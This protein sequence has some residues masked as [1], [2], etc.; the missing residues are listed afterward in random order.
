MNIA[1]ALNKKYVEYTAVMLLSLCMNNKKHH[2]DI[3]LLHSELEEN[4]IEKLRNT[5]KEYDVTLIETKVEKA[6]FEEKCKSSEQWSIETY[7]R[8]LLLDILPE[9]VERL[10][11]L[12][13]DMLIINDIFDMYN[14]E[15]NGN[16]IFVVKDMSGTLKNEFL[17]QKQ[18]E[19]FAPMFAQGYSYFNAGLLLYNIKEMR[20]KYSTNTYFDA[21]Q[22]WNYEMTAFDQDIMNYVH[23]KKVSYLDE[24]KYNVF[25]AVAH[26]TWLKDYA[27]VKENV[28]IIHY[29]GFMKPWH[30]KSFHNDIELI[31]WEYAK[32]TPFYNELLERFMILTMTD[33]TF[34]YMQNQR[35]A[36]LEQEKAAVIN[37]ANELV[38][39]IS[40]GGKL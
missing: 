34:E 12:D 38:N 21:M 27:W 25:A 39:A 3:Y 35:I 37:A 15:F 7:F 23:W 2:I 17:S 16:D 30:T 22:D 26:T 5:I 31:W 33:K 40:N 10:L 24:K 18:Q 29:G 11:Y 4:D 6:I 8:L 19:M 36:K 28:S 14:S 1:I 20:K 13:V 32:L 9:T